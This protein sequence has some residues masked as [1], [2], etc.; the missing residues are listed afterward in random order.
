MSSGATALGRRQLG[1]PAGVLRFAE[2]QAAAAVGQIRQAHANKELLEVH[3]V[4]V[5][6]VLLTLEDS[7][8][9]TRYLNARTTLA[10]LLGLG[11]CRGGR[12]GSGRRRTTHQLQ[13]CGARGRSSEAGM[14]L[15]A[16]R[17]CAA[18]AEDSR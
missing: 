11:A 7:E 13:I 16:D 1:L 15:A 9:R 6:Q 8:Q 4:T 5:A 3:A 10:A 12:Q 17:A 18:A 14:N 2:S